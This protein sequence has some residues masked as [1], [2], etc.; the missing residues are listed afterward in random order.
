MGMAANQ[1]FSLGESLFATAWAAAGLALCRAMLFGPQGFELL[2][3]V[4]SIC[5]CFGAAVGTITRRP[6]LG[7]VTALGAFPVL[8]PFASAMA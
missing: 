6:V 5:C 1:Q 3:V 7:V 2:A 8:L 4:V